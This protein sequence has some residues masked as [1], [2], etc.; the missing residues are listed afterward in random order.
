M[1]DE[2]VYRDERTTIV[3]NKSYRWAYYVV[4]FGLLAI[5]AY[6]GFVRNESNWD[7]MA[8]IILSSLVATLYQSYN[9]ILSRRT[10]LG[11]VVTALIAG[12]VAAIIVFLTK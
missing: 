8:L 2:P 3:E 12:V 6:R 7:L 1:K 10:W 11:V 5:V 9:K 4:S